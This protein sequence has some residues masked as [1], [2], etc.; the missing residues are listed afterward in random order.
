MEQKMKDKKAAALKATLEL[1]AEEGFQGAPMSQ[2]ARRAIT[3]ST[4]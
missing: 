1:I 4:K 2:I 3:E